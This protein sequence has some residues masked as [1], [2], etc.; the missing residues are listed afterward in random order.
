MMSVMSNDSP[1]TPL[2]YLANRFQVLGF[3]IAGYE[4]AYTFESKWCARKDRDCLM[5]FDPKFGVVW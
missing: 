4:T 1:M 3:K 2:Q 5:K